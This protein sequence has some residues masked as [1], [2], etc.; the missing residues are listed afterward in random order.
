MQT[1]PTFDA[2]VEIV[3]ARD[4]HR[5]ALLVAHRNGQT[6]A[7]AEEIGFTAGLEFALDALKNA[8]EFVA[9]AE[10]LV[11]CHRTSEPVA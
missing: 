1:T 9:S 5:D 3:R 7:R 8:G 10:Y 11:R 2:I 6:H 4:A